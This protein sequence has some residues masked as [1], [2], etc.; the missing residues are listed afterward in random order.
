MTL[1]SQLLIHIE[2]VSR[3]ALFLCMSGKVSCRRAAAGYSHQV[4]LSVDYSASILIALQP[5]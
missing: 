2:T 1:H 3:T 5:W 4:E